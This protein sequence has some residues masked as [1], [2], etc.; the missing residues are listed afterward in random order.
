MALPYLN[1]YKARVSNAPVPTSEDERQLL[2]DCRKIMNMHDLALEFTT[3]KALPD[4]VIHLNSFGKAKS[5][6]P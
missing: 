6:A 1:S 4:D 5:F 2:K 3:D